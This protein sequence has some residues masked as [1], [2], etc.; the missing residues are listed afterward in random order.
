MHKWLGLPIPAKRTIVDTKEKNKDYDKN[1]RRRTIV[2]SWKEE[3]KWLISDETATNSGKLYCQQ[4]RG[5][6]GPLAIRKTASDKIKRYANGPFV[7]GSTNLKH[8]ALTTHEKSEGHKYAVEITASR[9]KPQ[10]ESSAEKI[11]HSLNKA[12]VS[13][14]EKL[15]RNAHAVAK[16]S[17]PI[18]DYVWLC[19]LDEQKGV[20]LGST[21]KNH[22]SCKE[23][24][25]SIAEVE[26]YKIE[27]KLA[28][29][30]FCT[31]MSD[32][33][34][35][36]SVSE[37]EIVYIHFAHRGVPYCYFLGLIECESANSEGIYNAIKEAL[38]FK[39]ISVDSVLKKTIA[40]AGDGASVNTGHL[41]GVIA[42]FRRNVSPSIIMV[43]CMSHRVELAYKAALKVRVLNKK[44]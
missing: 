30:K 3:F 5:I 28:E 17:R 35:D 32:G 15:F 24:M 42:H 7:V 18:T 39:N 37:N 2:P 25:V 12:T 38:H 40:F 26:R 36:V 41:N 43:Q 31:I 16:K 14:L 8:D 21:Y 4:C 33:S 13:K 1:K 29:V 6:Y 22:K 9:N 44:I 27:E 20:H 10:G 11:L 34:T 23:F 19:E